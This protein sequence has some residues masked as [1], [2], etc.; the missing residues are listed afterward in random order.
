MYITGQQV[1]GLLPSASQLL[2]SQVNQFLETAA[3]EIPTP[4]QVLQA[5]ESDEETQG[6]QQSNILPL[7]L[8]QAMN[9][10]LNLPTQ[11]LD[12]T[13]S[14]GESLPALPKRPLQKIW[15][16]EYIDL[17]ELPP[18]KGDTSPVGG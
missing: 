3:G 4:T 6:H 1:L 12:S 15:N 5:G 7:A 17:S 11:S 10:P 8:E 13:V 14:I 9:G 2:E 18:A 16:S